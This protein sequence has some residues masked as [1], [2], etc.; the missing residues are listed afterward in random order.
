VNDSDAQVH[1]NARKIRVVTIFAAIIALSAVIAIALGLFDPPL[2]DQKWLQEQVVLSV[3]AENSP[4]TI[5]LDS[6]PA[7]SRGVRLIGKWVGGERDSGYGIL[8]GSANDHI[9]LAVS[10]LGY[11]TIWEVDDTIHMPWQP[12]VHVASE[13]EANEFWFDWSGDELILRLNREI[14]WR[15]PKNGFCDRSCEMAVWGTTFGDSAEFQ[16]EDA[17][18]RTGSAE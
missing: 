2:P 12:W 18:I 1:K 14:I 7:K 17:Y 13:D 11:A 3:S 16:F 6:L 4:Q 10:P 9:G 5:V 15:Q 8:L